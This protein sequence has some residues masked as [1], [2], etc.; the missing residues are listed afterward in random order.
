ML[1]LYPLAS[2]L[3]VIIAGPLAAQQPTSE[4]RDAIR[5]ACRN[6]FIANCSGVQPGTKEAL[7]CLLRFEAK[8]S[9]ACKTAVSAVAASPGEPAAQNP[10]TELPKAPPTEAKE[11]QMSAV[12]QACTLNDFVAHCSWIQPSSPEVLLCLRAN[13]AS[14]S[15]PCQAALQAAPA[16]SSPTENPAAAETP[17]AESAPVAPAVPARKPQTAAPAAAAAP[18]APAAAAKPAGGPSAEERSAIRAACH[19]DFMSH[20]QG[21]KPGGA[22]ALQCLQRNAAQ[23][24]PRCRSAVAAIGNGAPA[25]GASEA[26]APAAAPATAPMGPMPEMRPRE[27]LAIL[28]ICSG[29]KRRLCGDMPPGGGRIIACLAANAASLSPG[30]RAALMSAARR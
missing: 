12:R 29:D 21:V 4:Q 9:A 5:S 23:L 26:T 16:G 7:E 8:L 10:P 3:L 17:P 24:S 18:S 6:D 13:L 20:C 2:L 30:C 25:A 14:L 27:A 28:R 15:A 1:K 22:Q 19:S 11:D